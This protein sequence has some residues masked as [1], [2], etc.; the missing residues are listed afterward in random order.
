MASSEQ[1]EREAN[2]TRADIDQTLAELRAR[3][4]P[5][6]IVDQAT[7]Y[8]SKRMNGDVV[9]TLARH[10]ADRPVP[11][12]LVAAGLAWLLMAPRHRPAVDDGGGNGVNRNSRE[13]LRP[14]GGIAASTEPSGAYAG[15]IINRSTASP[16]LVPDSV[17]RAETEEPV[18]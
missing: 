14:S 9:G 2:A 7:D 15:N 12:L 13:A 4:S 17:A 5:Q 10:I 1:L 16:P 11:F 3:I 6:H 8:A 18:G